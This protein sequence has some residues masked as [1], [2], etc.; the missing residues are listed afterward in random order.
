[1]AGLSQQVAD[2]LSTP[3]CGYTLDVHRGDT[4][5]P[6]VQWLW[7]EPLDGD[8]KLAL[9]RGHAV[10]D[11]VKAAGVSPGDTSPYEAHLTDAVMVMDECPFQP[12]VCSGRHVVV[13]G[14]G[15]LST[16]SI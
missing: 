10:F 4:N 8:E 2:V 5:G 6:I 7:G 15:R 12:A 14:R 13:S 9:D 3:G 16:V 1:M 11:A